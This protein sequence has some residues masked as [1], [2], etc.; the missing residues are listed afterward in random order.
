MFVMLIRRANK[1][2]SEPTPYQAQAIGQWV[3]A[4][5]FV[6]NIG[7]EQRIDAWRKGVRL[8]Y[9][10]QAKELTAAVRWRT[11]LISLPV[12]LGNTTGQWHRPGRPA[13]L[14]SEVVD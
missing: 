2:C 13:V 14:K 10:A 7:L 12:T 5:R 9:N 4:T 6:F 8:D 3:G 11:R 1:Y